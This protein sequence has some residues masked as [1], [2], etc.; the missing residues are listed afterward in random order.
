[1]KTTAFLRAEASA[2][3][4]VFGATIGP[5]VDSFHNQCLLRYDVAPITI[6]W[7]DFM[8]HMGDV[9]EQEYMFCGSWTVPLLLGFAY[10]VLGDI[11]PR[12]FTLPISA[13]MPQSTEPSTVPYKHSGLLQK[14]AIAAVLTTCLIIKLS[15]YL[16]LHEPLEPIASFLPFINSSA[17]ANYDLLMIFAFIQ[18]ALLDGTVPAFLAA[19][20]TSVGGPLSELPFVAKGVWEYLPQAADYFPLAEV[21]DSLGV[22]KFVLGESYQD[23][24]LSSITGPCYFAVTMDAIALGRWFQQ[25]TVDEQ[26]AP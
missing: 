10:V 1:M 8:P 13:S 21:N 2:K 11:L 20:V 17:E 23:L 16:E 5:I 9:F 12:V 25:S 7:P 19:V 4:F 6:P 15:Q 24:A 22:L 3:L 14:K 18:W 26:Y